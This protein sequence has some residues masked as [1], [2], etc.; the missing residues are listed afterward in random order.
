MALASFSR[1]VEIHLARHGETDDN[2]RCIFQGQSGRGLN[3][4]GRAQAEALGR[5]LRT[6]PYRAILT[7]DLERAQETAQI[8]AACF[9]GG[10][11]IETDPGLREIDLGAWTGKS[12][13]D[14]AELSLPATGRS[15]PTRR[16]RLLASRRMPAPHVLP[17]R[18]AECAAG[19]RRRPPETISS[20]SSS[21]A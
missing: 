7:S 5:R 17:P 19:A 8:I 21:R 1:T 10:L 18:E 14:I 2:A 11:P 20:G 12:H 16:T 9:P 6:Q 4:R 13:D 3:A 15:D